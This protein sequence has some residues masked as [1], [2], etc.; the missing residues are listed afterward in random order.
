MTRFAASRVDSEPR[1]ADSA[2][3][4]LFFDRVTQAPGVQFLRRMLFQIVAKYDRHEVEGLTAGDMVEAISRTY[5]VA[6]QNT[7][8][9]EGH[10][11]AIQR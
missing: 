7:T 11:G 5:G 9:M 3:H 8:P 2:N 10:P 6:V 4:I 1:I